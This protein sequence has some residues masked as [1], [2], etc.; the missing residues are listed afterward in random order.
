MLNKLRNFSK[1][2]LAGVLVG[3]IIIPFVFWG[4]GS[5]FSGGNTN[6]IAK[7][8]NHNVSTQDFADFV[9]NSK[10]STEV[11]KE[12][13]NNNILEEL[14]AQLVST[15]LID[16]EINELKVFMS[17]QILVKKL[18]KQKTFL[19]ENNNFSRTKY[20]KFLLE[21]N[22]SSIK[23]EQGIK[24]NELKKT[25]FTY[26]GG[27]VRSP[28]F[29]I[30]KNYKDQSKKIEVDFIDLSSTYIKKN[31][32]TLNDVEKHINEN[33]ELFLVE[34]IDISLIKLTPMNISGEAEFTDNFFSKIDEIE[35]LIVSNISINEISERFNLKI[36]NVKNYY[37]GKSTD[38][39]LDDIYKK[40]N[41]QTLNILDKNDFF[42]LYEIKN[43]KKVLPN[44]EDDEFVKMVKTDLFEKSKFNIN[45]DLMK[46]IQERKFTDDDFSKL[47]NG[48]IKNLKIQSIKDTNTFTQDSISLL[49]SLGINN[50]SLVTDKNNNIYLVK[51]KNIY[52]NN[53]IKNGK[54]DK[55]F[56]NQTNIKVRNNLYN[57]YDLLLN[58]K[59]KIEI[60][61]N[62]LDRMKNYFR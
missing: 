27:G 26:I 31:E 45:K 61:A 6:S 53:L 12:N 44:L 10:I 36:E 57:S 41:E 52:E 7:I 55:T 24:D 13:I 19:D 32:I 1:G 37:P 35:E 38:L 34:Q 42:L 28:F 5:V 40:R 20:E 4:M 49:Y 17:D 14:L 46:K 54:E 51:I 62:T 58:E 8:N 60:N 25:L 11:I 39:M 50:F 23:F 18:K 15:S 43:L 22:M 21:N 30:N 9:N 59:Y 3:I 33:K 56:T 2:K 47:S 16:I 48:P 29:L